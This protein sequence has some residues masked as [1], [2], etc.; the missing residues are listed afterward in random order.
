[1]FNVLQTKPIPC[2]INSGNVRKHFCLRE[3]LSPGAVLAQEL[4]CLFSFDQRFHQGTIGT[5]NPDVKRSC[6][7]CR[8]HISDFKF[9]TFQAW[10]LRSNP[11]VEG[12]EATADRHRTFN[13]T[14]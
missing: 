14:W 2:L 5:S 11:S 13:P 8:E 1:M 9:Q 4:H 10:V 12:A 6:E 3:I 7:S